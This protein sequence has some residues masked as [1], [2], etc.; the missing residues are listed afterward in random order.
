MADFKILFEQLYVLV[1]RNFKLKYKSTALGFCWSLLVPLAQAMVY[2]LVFSNVSRFDIRAYLLYM[3]SGIFLW[4]FFTAVMSSSRKCFVGDAAL[5]K[6]TSF[7]RALLVVGMTIT[8]F[9][10]LLLTIPILIL[11]MLY[12]GILP[13]WSLLN[14]FVILPAAF[15]FAMGFAFLIATMN[16]YLRDIERILSVIIH[17][18]F[19][20]SPILYTPENV[21]GGFAKVIQFNPMLYFMTAWRNVFYQPKTGTEYLGI[22]LAMGCAAAVAGYLVYRRC[23]PDFAEKM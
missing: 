22:I 21:R 1:E 18:W 9:L 13:G 2:F 7:N 11:F 19:F 6:K 10:H 5:I 4:H 8:E 23:E 17:M 15:L 12:Y 20:A 16:L 14:I 3:L